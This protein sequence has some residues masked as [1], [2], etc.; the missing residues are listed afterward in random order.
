MWCE[1]CDVCGEA[2]VAC[3][4]AAVMPMSRCS[5]THVPAVSL[6][7]TGAH[8]VDLAIISNGKTTA[9]EFLSPLRSLV[10]DM[11]HKFIAVPRSIFGTRQFVVEYTSNLFISNC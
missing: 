10:V 3:G 2:T 1:R 8:F 7:F 5:G 9:L 11:S 4:E 6:L